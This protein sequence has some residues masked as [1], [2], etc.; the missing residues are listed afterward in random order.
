MFGNEINGS[1][2]MKFFREGSIRGMLNQL[3]KLS[4]NN[5][6]AILVGQHFRD[7]EVYFTST[8]HPN[9]D[10]LS[11]LTNMISQAYLIRKLHSED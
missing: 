8:T 10:P 2:K 1:Y 4:E 11:T 6:S 3:E 5:S 7:I 9:G